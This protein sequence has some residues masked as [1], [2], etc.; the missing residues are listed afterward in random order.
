MKK[1][2]FFPYNTF[3]VPS[4]IRLFCFSHSGG[5]A[6]NF[7][8]WTNHF[9]SDVEICPIQLPGRETR[10]SDPLITSMESLMDALWPE[11]LQLF[12]RPCG[13]FGHSLGAIVAFEIAKRMKTFSYNQLRTLFV[14]ACSA[15]TF[16]NYHSNH[17]HLGPDEKI[18]QSLKSYGAMPA[19]LLQNE[20]ALALILPR[21]RA[22]FSIF[23]TYNYQSTKPLDIPIV[24]CNGCDDS[25][26]SE[27]KMKAWEI[28]T[29]STFNQYTFNGGHFYHQTNQKNLSKVILERLIT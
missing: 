7:R 1:L 20:E 21:I 12:D 4:K 9:S 15:P 8:E 11:I 18:I 5:T 17:V 10:F 24:A 19:Q 29:C 28:E 13:L 22:D 3:A 14:S 27:S 23:E 6:S 16:L 25:I 2:S 26:V